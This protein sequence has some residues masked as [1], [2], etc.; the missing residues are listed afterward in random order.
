MSISED[1]K[2]ISLSMNNIEPENIT[3]SPFVDIETGE[4][5]I[6]VTYNYC[7]YENWK[8]VANKILIN[9]IEVI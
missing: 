4:K 5:K 2:T 8:F 9:N 1:R 3:L 7:G 6:L